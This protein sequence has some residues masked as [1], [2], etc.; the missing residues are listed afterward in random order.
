ML[1]TADG[2]VILRPA[3]TNPTHAKQ[4]ER[5]IDVI[6]MS[7][8]WRAVA[9]CGAVLG[10]GLACEKNTPTPVPPASAPVAGSSAGQEDDAKAISA[11]L[12]KD[13]PSTPSGVLPPNHPPIEGFAP[14]TPNLPQGHPPI[15][16][17]TGM[18]AGMKPAPE[19]DAI[20]YTAPSDWKV[21][22]VTS[23]L[24]K[25]QYLLPR[26]EGDKED[27]QMVVFY[28]GEGQGGAVEANIDRWKG[29]F[30]TSDGKPIP[31]AE[32]KRESHDVNGMKVTTLDVTGR[33]ADPMSGRPASNDAQE[34]RMLSAIVET[35]QGPWFFKGV[36]P[37]ATMKAQE[38]NFNAFVASIKGKP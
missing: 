20:L 28:F 23:S 24:R 6:R 31:D 16:P 4:R 18:G 8:Y 37:V 29:M 2:E 15:G 22:P 9:A 25:A 34:F 19:L 17:A 5:G 21:Q 27:G 10:V 26:A 36:G 33:Y 3:E 32:V 11:F 14:P 13:K 7:H 30:S 1:Q 38:Q 12:N 35:P